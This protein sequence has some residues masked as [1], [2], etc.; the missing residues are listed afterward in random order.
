VNKKIKLLKPSN[1][2]TSKMTQISFKR[3]VTLDTVFNTTH[4]RIAMRRPTVELIDLH[5]RI[6]PTAASEEPSIELLSIICLLTLPTK[7]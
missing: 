3:R 7:Q 2:R 4:T 6:P 1:S 5:N